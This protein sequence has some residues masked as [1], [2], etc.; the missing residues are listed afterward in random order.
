MDVEPIMKNLGSGERMEKKNSSREK[1][2]G[3]REGSE[4]KSRDPT[5]GIGIISRCRWSRTVH[6]EN[7]S[8]I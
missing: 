2:K 8:E 3:K 4:S 1:G 6:L 5:D 7:N